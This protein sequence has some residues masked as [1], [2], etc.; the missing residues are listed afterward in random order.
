FFRITAYAER[1][2]ADLD[3]LEHW[4]E[5]VKTMQRNWIG[6]SE[7]ARVEFK[8]ASTGDPMP[9]FTTRPDTLWGCTYMVLAVEHPLVEKL[10]A[11]AGDRAGDLRA[12]VARVKRLGRAKR[13]DV[14]LEKEGIAT[15]EDAVNPVNGRRIPVWLANYVVMEYG[16]GAVM[17]VPAH[18]D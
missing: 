14:T 4:P 1:L 8:L 9:V 7:G 6:R 13:G 12:F 5:R 18:D 17:A 16:T 11:R 15:G 10:I 2:L 3:H